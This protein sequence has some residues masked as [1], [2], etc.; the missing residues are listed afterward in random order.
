MEI[1]DGLFR[2]FGAVKDYFF[3]CIRYFFSLL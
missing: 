2:F 3:F 1:S